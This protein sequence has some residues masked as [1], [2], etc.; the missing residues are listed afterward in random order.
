[1]RAEKVFP[2][3]PALR[4]SLYRRSGGDV[5]N[6]KALNNKI[7]C[8]THIP[9]FVPKKK[10]KKKKILLFFFFFFKLK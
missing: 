5:H 3:P 8:T 1:M 6:L 9:D 7:K 10:K 2:T 4:T